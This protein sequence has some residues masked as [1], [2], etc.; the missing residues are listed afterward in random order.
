MALMSRLGAPRTATKR[1]GAQYQF[2]EAIS[3]RVSCETQQEID[4]LWNALTANGGQESLCGWLKDKYG[5][6]WQIVPPILGE[7]L[8]DPDPEK[9]GRVMQAM[10]QMKKIDIATLKQAY[11]GK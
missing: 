7:L 9:A 10:L 2:T 8:G 4:A 5:L 11:A 1:N 3:L 6:S